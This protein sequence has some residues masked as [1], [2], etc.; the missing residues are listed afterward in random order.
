MI[1]VKE[2]NYKSKYRKK[3]SS[4]VPNMIENTK[5]I[6]LAFGST[7]LEL[8]IPERNVSSIILPSEPE[9]K[10]RSNLFN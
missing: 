7:A 2:D 8:D 1:A 3:R 6:S 5:T 4:E 9:K 10:G